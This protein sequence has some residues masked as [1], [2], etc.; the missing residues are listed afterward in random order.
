MMYRM[1][2]SLHEVEDLRVDVRAVDAHFC[3]SP[4]Y[5]HLVTGLPETSV[6]GTGVQTRPPVSGGGTGDVSG[7]GGVKLSTQSP[8]LPFVL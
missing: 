2:T 1:S 8:H 6:V 5:P 4:V 3:A 7:A